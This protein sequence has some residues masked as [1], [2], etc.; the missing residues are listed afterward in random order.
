MKGINLRVVQAKLQ[1]TKGASAVPTKIS[2]VWQQKRVVALNL[3]HSKGKY[4][5]WCAYDI[6][7]DQLYFNTW[8]ID[9]RVE[10]W[11]KEMIY[12]EKGWD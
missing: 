11:I 5:F 9:N 8:I 6:G 7:P 2:G 1:L 12:E 10:S 4:I 3:G